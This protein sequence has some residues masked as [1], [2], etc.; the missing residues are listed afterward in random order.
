MLNSHNEK[1]TIMKTNLLLTLLIIFTLNAFAQGPEF[2]KVPVSVPGNNELSAT[3]LIDLIPDN[4]E[5]TNPLI[6]A[7]GFDAGS[8]TDP[9]SE[10][11]DTDI[12]DFTDEVFFD[13]GLQ[14]GNLL[15]ND[16]LRTYDIIYVNWDNGVADMRDNSL[17]L[18]AVIDWV[19][20]EKVGNEPNVLLGQSMGGVIGRYTLARMEE[21]D[22]NN[23]DVH[24]VGL[25]IAHDAPMQGA[26]TPIATQHFARHIYNQYVQAPIGYFLGQYVL[27]VATGLA[28]IINES[29]I[30]LGTNTSV[31]PYINPEDVLTIQDTPAAVQLNY[32][33][34]DFDE[35]VQTFLHES[36]QQELESKGYPERSRNVAISN[37]NEC[38]Q[39]QG[40]NPGDQLVDVHDKDTPDFFGDLLSIFYV[41]AIGVVL[42]DIGLTILSSIPGDSEFTYVFDLRT[43]PDLTNTMRKVYYGRVSYTKKILWIGPSITHQITKREKNAPDDALPYGSYA[44]GA[45]DVGGVINELPEQFPPTT[46]V[47]DRYGFIPVVSALDIKRNEQ[48]VNPNDYLRTYAG[49][50]TPEPALTSAFDNFIV[51]ANQTA[52]INSPHI[53]FQTRNGNWLAAELNALDDPTEDTPVFDCSSF[54]SPTINGPDFVC[55][56]EDFSISADASYVYWSII[57][58]DHLVTLESNGNTATISQNDYYQTGAATVRVFFSSKCGTA[59]A[60]KTITVGRPNITTNMK[61]IG[62]NINEA[63]ATAPINSNTQLSL[64]N[65]ASGS[66][67][68]WIV[69]LNTQCQNPSPNNLPRFRTGPDSYAS[70]IVTSYTNATTFIDWGN[71]KGNYVVN[72]EALN[73]CGSTGVDHQYVEV[74]DPYDGNPNPDPCDGISNL[75][76]Y[77]NPVNGDN[78][79]VNRL[80][81]NPPCEPTANRASNT[82]GNNQIQNDVKIFNNL[83]VLV[84]Q[85]VF[86]SE[87]F[88]ITNL[89]LNTGFY[90]L[91]FTPI[92]EDPIQKVLVV[93]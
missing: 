65:Y 27:P 64:S 79:T 10:F 54:C 4:T 12:T 87:E 36:W 40:F 49:G 47:N 37:G 92:N 75:L 34:V 48:Q 3:L 85:N 29:L 89:N 23:P 67:R 56:S 28:E 63:N 1:Q 76:V 14:L 24:E 88:T 62:N 50:E 43:T 74:Y 13:G 11:G 26:N 81:V 61:I 71:C 91:H 5:V 25:F 19:N 52:P 35:N 80:P 7:E 9:E 39:D 16:T 59:S 82:G 22:P 70:E 17:V 8:I 77:P 15:V 46:L 21:E 90:I 41:P 73:E 2:F 45:F 58:G 33:W 38:G 60:T 32:Q 44:G 6:V 53:S 72:V 51:D 93:E 68:Y 69:P 86:N 66:Y 83:G 55:S 78:I 20:D 42:N 57:E 84:Y 31:E 30:I 18:E